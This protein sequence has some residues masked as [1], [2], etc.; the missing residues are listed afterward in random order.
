MKQRKLC[1]PDYKEPTHKNSPERAQIKYDIDQEPIV[2]S[3]PTSDIFL[4]QKHP[5]DVMALYW[6][7]YYTAKWQKTNKVYATTSFTAKALNWGK[8]RVR[9]TKGVL[10]KLRMVEDVI[11][12]NES[13]KITGHYIKVK[14]IWSKEK[15]TLRENHTLERTILWKSRRE[16]L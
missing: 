16:M 4:K 9:R 6:F 11:N 12:K 7:Y 1:N 15:T 14:F 2:I 10:I 5:T 8:D 3:K 13:G